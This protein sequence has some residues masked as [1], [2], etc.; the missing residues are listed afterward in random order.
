VADQLLDG[1]GEQR[2]VRL[3]GDDKQFDKKTK[4][5]RPVRRIDFPSPDDDEDALGSSWYWYV[6]PR[7]ADD[8]GSK[9]SL[10][11]VKWPDHT[12]DVTGNARK[13]VAA[14]NLPKEMKAAVV[15]AA[16]CHDL[17]KLREVWQRNIGN[18]LPPDPEP[19]DWL[20][21]SGRKR[22]LRNICPNYRHE[23][24]SLLDLLGENEGNREHLAKLSELSDEMRD[25]VLHM[26]A[27]SHGRAR[28]LGYGKLLQF[29]KDSAG[30][31]AQQL[32]RLDWIVFQ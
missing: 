26:I 28:T 14:L 1:Q 29:I 31:I 21:K 30:S 27:T 3:P 8:A 19:D 6:R 23:F 2:R 9:T 25:L 17:G 32:V 15:L 12:R 20:A 7:S 24:G 4:G 18:Q 11:S 22:P 5:M 16:E 10:K 13:I